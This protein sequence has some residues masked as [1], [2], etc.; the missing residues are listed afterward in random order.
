VKQVLFVRLIPFVFA[1]LILFLVLF[2]RLKKVLFAKLNLFLCFVML[3]AYHDL[4]TFIPL[5]QAFWIQTLTL[6]FVGY[7]QA[8]PNCYNYFDNLRRVALTYI[9]K[10]AAKFFAARYK[11]VIKFPEVY[12]VSF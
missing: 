11:N 4:L 2:A 3:I 6:F 5:F 1:R 8:L 10:W 7:L 12:G 9:K